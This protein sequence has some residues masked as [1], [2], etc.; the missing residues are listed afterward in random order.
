[1]INFVAGSCRGISGVPA[2]SFENVGVRED[3]YGVCWPK[4]VV[5]V[6]LVALSG[7]ME[8]GDRGQGPAC[9]SSLAAAERDL[10]A[11]KANSIGT[12]IDWAKAA[13]LIGAARSQQQFNEFQNL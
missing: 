3:M 11:A 10:V 12:V 2:E 1:M 7:C 8:P 4:F 6:T 9:E 13:A 5:F